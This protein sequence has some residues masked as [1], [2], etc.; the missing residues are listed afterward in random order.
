VVECDSCY[1]AVDES[2]TSLHCINGTWNKIM[3]Q[4]RETFCGHPGSPAN[5]AIV[6]GVHSNAPD[7][8]KCKM[9]VEYECEAGFTRIGDLKRR[10]KE[11]REWT[12]KVPTCVIDTCDPLPEVDN[13]KFI[14]SSNSSTKVS[15]LCDAGYTPF[16]SMSRKCIRGQWT[17]DTAYCNVHTCGKWGTMQFGQIESIK[18][19]K[20]GGERT[21]GAQIKYSCAGDR[22]QLSGDG[23][24]ECTTSGWSGKL[25]HCVCTACPEL[26]IINGRVETQYESRIGSSIEYVCDPGYAL[27]DGDNA[28]RTCQ[29]NGEWDGSDPTCV[30]VTCPRPEQP[31]G[32]LIITSNSD[33]KHPGEQVTIECDNDSKRVVLTCQDDR[34]WEG[35]PA[36]CNCREEQRQVETIVETITPGTC[37]LTHCTP[38]TRTNKTITKTVTVEV[39]DLS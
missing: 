14:N 29:E 9:E 36:N 17:G 4:C 22:Y 30:E 31:E 19:G 6:G 18:L 11:S 8:Y 15:Y 3:T 39:C 35:G 5:G 10:C 34:T 32:G 20:E 13:S 26:S 16:G 12:G 2:R 37:I 38:E 23:T 33:K 27:K 1:S 28:M 25:P 21:Y 24:R 7:Y